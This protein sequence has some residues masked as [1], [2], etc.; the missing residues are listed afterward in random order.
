MAGSLFGLGGGCFR[1]DGRPLPSSRLN[2]ECR[3]GGLEDGPARDWARPSTAA[4]TVAELQGRR[5]GPLLSSALGG[6]NEQRAP[7]EG[8]RGITQM[9]A[10][11]GLK[12]T[13]S[14]LLGKSAFPQGWRMQAALQYP[15]PLEAATP[16]FQARFLTDKHVGASS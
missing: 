5:L 6:E 14:R 3:E 13:S 8:P 9:V 1:G 15:G 7:A 16:S 11:N 4:G 12:H 10:A 2:T